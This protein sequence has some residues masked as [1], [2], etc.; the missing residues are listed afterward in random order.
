MPLIRFDLV[1]GRTDAELKTL[2]DAAHRAMLAAFKEV[3]LGA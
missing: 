1:E 3:E 2:L